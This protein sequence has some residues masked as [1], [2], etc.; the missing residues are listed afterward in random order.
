MTKVGIIT[1]HDINNYGAQLQAASLQSFLQQQGYDAELIHYLPPRTRIRVAGTLIRPLL[2]GK[3]RVFSYEWAKRQ[4]FR[5]SIQAMARVSSPALYTSTQVSQYCREQGFD[6]LVCGSDELW[7]FTNY[8][9]Y[10][11]PY[12]LDLD[13]PPGVKRISYAAS[14]GSYPG[15]PEIDDK[16]RQALQQFHRILVRDQH[17]REFI[18]RLGLDGNIVV[19][20]TLI[21][22]LEPELP[23]DQ[24]YVLITGGLSPKQRVNVFSFAESSGL[25]I[26]TPGNA[27]PGYEQYH[28]LVTPQQWIGLIQNARYH[29]TSLFHGAA[30]SLKYATP[31]ACFCT[32]GKERKIGFL[33]STFGQQERMMPVDAEADAIDARLQQAFPSDYGQVRSRI[34]TASQNQL[35]DALHAYAEAA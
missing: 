7:N 29:I 23:V 16:M 34:I 18:H 6:I 17:T 26:I 19:D 5:R 10:L 24:D 11:P 2:R 31:F 14:I 4:L 15:D 32:P 20:P 12:I 1:Y 13:L 3:H 28:R 35:L 21:A 25:P 22:D 8:L 33:L 27:Y 30:F 9:G